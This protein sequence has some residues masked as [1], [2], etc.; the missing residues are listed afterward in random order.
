MAESNH[1]KPSENE[2]LQP[3]RRDED[4]LP[5]DREPTIDDVRGNDG[6]HRALA[7]GCTA[8]VVAAI[9]AFWLVRVLVL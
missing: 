8:L 4:G 7:L 6:Q 1:D 3:D 5:L 9:A 2:G